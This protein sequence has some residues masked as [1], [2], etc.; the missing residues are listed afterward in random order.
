MT[1]VKPLFIRGKKN[2]FE[3]IAIH[4]LYYENNDDGLMLNCSILQ[5]G[6]LWKTEICIGFSELNRL[7]AFAYEKF[8]SEAISNCIAWHVMDEGKTL[9]ELDFDTTLGEPLILVN[10]RF[11]ATYH[12][13]CA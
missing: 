5:N 13:L 7:L 2:V 9:C 10:Y 3:Q 12:Q 4:S 11:E 6:E 8:G 1:I